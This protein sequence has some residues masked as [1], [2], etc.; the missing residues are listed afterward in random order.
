MLI[1]QGAY[2]SCVR[3]PLGQ[4]PRCAAARD[5]LL[6]SALGT[7]SRQAAPVAPPGARQR[8]PRAARQLPAARP[9]GPLRRPA[10]SPAAAR[11]PATPR[12]LP[13]LLWVFVHPGRQRCAA[14]TGRTLQRCRAAG[15]GAGRE[16]AGAL[17]AYRARQ[18]ALL[19]IRRRV[20]SD[21]RLLPCIPLRL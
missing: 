14:L 12:Q 18:E 13:V 1:R 15:L 4:Q 6:M 8:L 3:R 17:L 11:A 5:S 21:G 16:P 9:R 20:V 2:Q 19:L 10:A 7:H